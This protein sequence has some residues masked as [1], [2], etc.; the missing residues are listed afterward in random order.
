VPFT[1]DPHELTDISREPRDMDRRRTDDTSH[2]RECVRPIK[3][4]TK[5]QTEFPQEIAGISVWI[6][7]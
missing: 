6:K 1:Q 7:V 5:R 3:E 4:E 2:I